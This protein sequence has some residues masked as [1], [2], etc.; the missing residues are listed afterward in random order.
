[1]LDLIG[2][3]CPLVT[4][5]SLRLEKVI[6]LMVVLGLDNSDFFEILLLQLFP[7][8]KQKHLELLEDVFLPDAERNELVVGTDV[9]ADDSC[10]VGAVANM[11]S[12]EYLVAVTRIWIEQS[13]RIQEG[14][15]WLR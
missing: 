12:A 15:S 4:S 11:L 2:P 10:V 6:L 1:M 14:T 5:R 7:V 8:S 3:R 13:E 9:V